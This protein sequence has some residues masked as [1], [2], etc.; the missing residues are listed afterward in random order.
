MSNMP[1]VATYEGQ[2]TNIPRP[3]SYRGTTT[4]KNGMVLCFD[5]DSA[6]ADHTATGTYTAAEQAEA[7]RQSWVENPS[8]SNYNNPAG[9]VVNAPSAGITANASG[10]TPVQ[11]LPF[12]PGGIMQESKPYVE[13]SVG[14]GDLLGVAPGRMYLSKWTCGPCL[15]I[16]RTAATGTAAAPA[17][18]QA[19]LGR[20]TPT[21]E[22]MAGKVIRESIHAGNYDA[23]AAG[24]TET[25]VSVG[26][27]TS[28]F[29]VDATQDHILATS[30]ANDN[31]GIET[32]RDIT[33]FNLTANDPCFGRFKFQ[34]AD[35]DETELW[36]GLADTGTTLVTSGDDDR[37][38]FHK[39]GTG[40]TL[41][42]IC[43]EGGTETDEDLETAVADATDYECIFFWD[44]IGTVYFWVNGTSGGSSGATDI[45]ANI[46]QTVGLGLSFG[47]LNSAAGAETAKFYM[48]QAFQHN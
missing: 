15:G 42:S 47:I 24:F 3:F 29:S 48:A 34:L 43:E 4:L 39:V 14:I 26:A 1:G 11:L 13:I 5:S 6:A 22:Q 10:D 20:F 9:I 16:C 18:V 25:A 23:S 41:E 38:G 17:V 46:P 37:V 33:P 44:G 8:A 40:T 12:V 30:A 21:D 27:G 7:A 36:C 31:D 35:V 28:N 2:Q 19:D 32:Q 45:T